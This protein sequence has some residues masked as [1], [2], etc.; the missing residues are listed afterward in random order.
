LAL[1]EEPIMVMDEANWSKDGMDKKK[2]L[3]PCA[4]LDIPVFDRRTLR[5]CAVVLHELANALTRFSLNPP[6][7]TLSDSTAIGMAIS[8]VWAA[9][10]SLLAFKK[11]DIAEHRRANVIKFGVERKV[12]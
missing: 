8:Q 7:E 10:E 9:N 4:R 2:R 6:G 11:R 12:V 5:E 1:N 3:Y